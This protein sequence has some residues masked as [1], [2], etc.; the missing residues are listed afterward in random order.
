[1]IKVPIADD[2]PVEER[3][4]K[5]ILWGA[6]EINAEDL[7]AVSWS[8]QEINSWNHEYRIKSE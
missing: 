1:M 4:Q 8:R 7:S 6:P 2:H 3:E 5:T